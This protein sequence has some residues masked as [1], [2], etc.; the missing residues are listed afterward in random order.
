[1]F[2]FGANHT[3]LYHQTHCVH[4]SQLSVIFLKLFPLVSF[5][6]GPWSPFIET[7][8]LITDQVVP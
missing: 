2:C 3:H 1:M 6:I 4:A 5:P 7:M 8:L